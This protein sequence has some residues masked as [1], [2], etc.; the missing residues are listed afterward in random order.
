MSAAEALARLAVRLRGRGTVS[1]AEVV[2]EAGPHA[3]AVCAAA[4]A[5]LSLLPVPGVG[6]FT[7]AVL[8]ASAAAMMRGGRVSVP[9]AAG[10][11][12][13]GA[14]PVSRALLSSARWVK[15]LEDRLP[16]RL[17]A[18]ALGPGARAA[19]GAMIGLCGLLVLIPFPGTNFLPAA[20]ALVLSIGALR[21]DRRILACGAGLFVLKTL[22]LGLLLSAVPA[23]G[24]P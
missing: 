6:L 8:V 19:A 23:A 7:G 16:R 3:P 24:R 21:S 14:R 1:Y 13:A 5:A 11:V 18:E 9:E 20:V 12:S 2:E 17:A 15:R 4:A 22:A 10:R